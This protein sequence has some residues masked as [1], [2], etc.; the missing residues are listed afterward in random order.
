MAGDPLLAGGD[1][2]ALRQEPRRRAALAN[3][4]QRVERL[5]ERD[6]HRGAGGR[7]DL[8]GIDLG[9]HAAARIFRRRAAGHRLDFGRDARDDRDEPRG[10]IGMGRRRVETVDVG[11]Q[12]QQIGAHHRGDARGEAVIVAIADLGRRNRVVLV[13]D[14]DRAEPQQRADRRARVQIA[15]ALLG[16]AERQQ[17]SVRRGSNGGRAAPNRRGRA[18]SGRPRPPPGFPRAAARRGAAP[19]RRARARSRRRRRA[20]L[21]GRRKR[22]PRRRRRAPSS[23]SSRSLPSARSTRSAEPILTTMRRKLRLRLH[24]GVVQRL[25]HGPSRSWRPALRSW[26]PGPR[27]DRPSVPPR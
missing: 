24:V 6:R 2:I 1:R 22:A 4:S 16:V 27:S 14:G 20:G 10:G 23:H 15:A 3:A 13:D 19:A 5:A 8:A 21:R 12:D 7:C 26:M 9:L 18:R 25:Q 11:E 17:I